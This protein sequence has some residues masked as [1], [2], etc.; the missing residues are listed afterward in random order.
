[1]F[2]MGFL[3][4]CLEKSNHS[5]IVLAEAN[6]RCLLVVLF[7]FQ[8]ELPFSQMKWLAMVSLCF[9]PF[10]F[11]QPTVT[12]SKHWFSRLKSATNSIF[13]FP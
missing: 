7:I 4:Q 13:F 6:V 12:I 3:K 2:M 8:N 5:L 1:M 11:L 10:L 9:C